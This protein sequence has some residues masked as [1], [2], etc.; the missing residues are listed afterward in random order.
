MP[1][2]TAEEAFEQFQNGAP[3]FNHPGHFASEAEWSR[4]KHMVPQEAKK[5]FREKVTGNEAR[6]A[7]G[8]AQGLTPEQMGVFD[9]KEHGQ[10]L[11]RR[12]AMGNLDKGFDYDW[13][14]GFKTNVGTSDLSKRGKERI[15]ITQEERQH[16][17]QLEAAKRA[18]T[19]IFAQHRQQ[20]I[21]QLLGVGAIEHDPETG[22]F[23]NPGGGGQYGRNL[24]GYNLGQNVFGQGRGTGGAS[25][26]GGGYSPTTISGPVR[27]GDSGFTGGTAPPRTGGGFQ[28]PP[29]VSPTGVRG[30]KPGQPIGIMPAP[31]GPQ[32]PAPPLSANPPSA[33]TPMT[34]TAP[35]QLAAPGPK[36]GGMGASLSAPPGVNTG[37]VGRPS[38]A[39]VQA[40][41]P[42]AAAPP[43]GV[44]V[45]PPIATQ[46]PAGPT[47]PAIDGQRA[48]QR[49]MPTPATFQASRV[50][51]KEE[52][53][54][55]GPG[56]TAQTPWGQVVPKEDG[57]PQLV[58]DEAGKAAYTAARAKAMGDFGPV[59]AW[60]QGPGMPPPPVE[61]GRW[62]FNPMTGMWSGGPA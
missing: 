29:G 30:E 25:V 48:G 14:S 11:L 2:M 57:T 40:A 12:M 33:P 6:F 1:G 58:L 46:Q 18:G 15:P 45:A 41:R 54:A 27:A 60:A 35:G 62:N 26:P 24:E 36:P 3:Y 23:R 47:A 17:Q 8:Q 59:P 61:P 56:A 4:Y 37:P 51:S 31:G 32:A 34:P 13:A 5:A 21:A 52:F 42:F 22:G 20:Q 7:E 43:T 38:T 55:L 16:Q 39:P 44:K 28:P 10:A 19:N 49:P 50:P 53:A 9:K